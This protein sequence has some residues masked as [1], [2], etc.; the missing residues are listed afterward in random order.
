MSDFR[1]AKGRQNTVDD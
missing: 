1:Q